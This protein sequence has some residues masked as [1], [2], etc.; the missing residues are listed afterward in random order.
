LLL[1]LVPIVFLIVAEAVGRVGSLLVSLKLPQMGLPVAL[2][3]LTLLAIKTK[4]LCFATPM[5]A[6][7]C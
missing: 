5:G 4:L 3:A 7:A 6:T 1:F 2:M